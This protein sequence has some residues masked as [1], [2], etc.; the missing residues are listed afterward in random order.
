MCMQGSG[1]G[2]ATNWASLESERRFLEKQP[3]AL[4]AASYD[5]VRWYGFLFLPLF[6]FLRAR[7]KHSITSSRCR[8]DIHI[9]LT[10]EFWPNLELEAYK[11]L[12][13]PVLFNRL[14]PPFFPSPRESCHAGSR[15]DRSSSLTRTRGARGYYRTVRKVYYGYSKAC[16]CFYSYDIPYSSMNEWSNN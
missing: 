8:L 6:V 10:F 15:N 12:K 16:L 13:W 14:M 3:H 7:D 11:C 1:G 5:T 9:F 2:G 4:T